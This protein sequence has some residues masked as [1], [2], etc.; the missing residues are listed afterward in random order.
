[1]LLH[2]TQVIPVFHVFL[3][4]HNLIQIRVQQPR[5]GENAIQ[6]MLGVLKNNEKAII[7][8]QSS[9]LMFFFGSPTQCRGSQ[10][11][12]S[13][14]HSQPSPKVG[15]SLSPQDPHPYPAQLMMVDTLSLS[16]FLIFYCFLSYPSP[17]ILLYKRD[18]RSFFSIDN[19][20]F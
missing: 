7:L 1:M 16:C 10:N 14:D 6:N 20:Y 4:Q 11:S 2:L 18:P 19:T 8:L 13:S 12:P 3:S 17:Q 15:C 9:F 5:V